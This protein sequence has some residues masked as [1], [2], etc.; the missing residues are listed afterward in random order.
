MRILVTGGTGTLGRPVVAGLR[1]RG[2]AV[3][4]LSRRPGGGDRVVGDLASGEGVRAAVE[5]VDAIVHAASAVREPWR[6]G[7][8]D[9]DGTAT[10]GRLA[11]EAGVGHLLYV[12]I[13]GIDRVPYRYYRA[14][15]GAEAAVRGCGVPWSSLRITQFHTLVDLALRVLAGPPLPVLAVPVDWRV[16]PIDPGD[17]AAAV[18]E[19][20][21]GDPGGLLPEVGGPEVRTAGEL[22]HAWLRAGDRRR[23]VVRLPLRGRLDRAM[24]AGGLCTP[25]RAVGRVGWEDWLSRRSG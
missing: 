1:E 21:L 11:R 14:K 16:Q 2:H 20:V 17:A 4:V 8:V 12:S 19:A 5:G 6:L 24:R 23:R 9:V 13:V 3:R 18:V 7:A 22:A 15:L 10:L 25:G